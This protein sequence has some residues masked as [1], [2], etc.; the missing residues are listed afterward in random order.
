MTEYLL[1]EMVE[2]QIGQ[3]LIKFLCSLTGVFKLLL[4]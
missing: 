1:L 4:Y 2:M 3:C